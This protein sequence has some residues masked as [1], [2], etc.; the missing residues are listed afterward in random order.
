MPMAHAPAIET[1]ASAT[2]TGLGMPVRSGRPRSSS[3]AWAPIPTASAKAAT[4]APSR[5]QA[6]IGARHPPM[7]TYERCQA[8]YGGWSSVT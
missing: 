3:S 7:T 8:V 1:A 5:P 2:S 6:T 4:A